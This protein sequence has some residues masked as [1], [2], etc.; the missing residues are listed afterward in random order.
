M[1]DHRSDWSAI[2][3]RFGF[4][5]SKNGNKT[6]KRNTVVLKLQV[7]W[8]YGSMKW[9]NIKDMKALYPLELAEYAFANN[10]NGEPALNWWFKDILRT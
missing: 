7:E 8:K 1:C 2:P 9:F 6:P 5:V 3:K 4:N 10:I